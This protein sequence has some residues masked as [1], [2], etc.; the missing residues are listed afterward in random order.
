[1]GYPVTITI[2]IDAL[3]WPAVE[4]SE[5]LRWLCPFRKPVHT[6][7]GYS[8]AAVPSILTG[9]LPQVHG[10]WSYLYYDPAHSPFAWTRWLNL[11]GPLLHN[12]F[13]DNPLLKRWIAHWTARRR[14]FDGYF[15]I[16]DFPL[17]YLHLMDHCSKRWDFQPGAFDCPSLIDV[18]G[19]QGMPARFLTYPTPEEEIFQ[20]CGEE[21]RPDGPRL[22][23]LYL[24]SV[25]ALGHAGGP[26]SPAIIS[27]LDGYAHRIAE[28]VETA[29]RR[30]M[31]LSLFVFSDHGM[32]PVRGTVDIRRRIESLGLRFG[33]DYVAVYDSTMARFWYLHPDS[34]PR[35]QKALTSCPGGRLLTQD[36]KARYGIAFAGDRFGQ[37]IFLLQTGLVIHPS[38]MSRRVL[39]AMHGY[40]PDD[41]INDGVFLASE[42]PAFEPAAITDFFPLLLRQLGILAHQGTAG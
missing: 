35:I 16:Y 26:L 25:D 30:E 6:I 31:A 12:R 19:Q 18:L 17:R 42:R 1:M 15:P 11:A 32:V 27:R 34:R 4:K 37:D 24:A 3:S 9:R 38:H 40:D 36:E 5:F 8:S 7:L 2:L 41:H 13:V 14:G 33:M 29:G 28:L 39:Q 10:R 20:R 23:F 21:L 22:F